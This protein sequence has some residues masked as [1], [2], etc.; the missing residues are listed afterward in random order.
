MTDRRGTHVTAALV[1]PRPRVL[2][3]AHAMSAFGQAGNRRDN[4]DNRGVS[5]RGRIDLPDG[6]AR[7]DDVQRATSQ[8]RRFRNAGW[9]IPA[10]PIIGWTLWRV[11]GGEVLGV[12]GIALALAGVAALIWGLQA[13][14]QTTEVDA[15]GIRL[16]GTEYWQLDWTQIK[17]AVAVA[18]VL[19][20][21]PTDELTS[22]MQ[23]DDRLFAPIAQRDAAHLQQ[24]IDH[25]LA[26][27][28]PGSDTRAARPSAPT[29][30]QSQLS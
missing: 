29:P 19:M 5:I 21:T 14:T 13:T 15:A 6:Y 9:L 28:V 10:L 25:Y 2:K 20:V 12:T 11:I 22:Q 30:D 7:S 18:D 27:A 26:P 24:V 8:R 23:L 1:A 3:L 4:W 16:S 17:A